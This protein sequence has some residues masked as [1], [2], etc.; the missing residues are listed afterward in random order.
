M[1]QP[2]HFAGGFPVLSGVPTNHGK[3]TG[4]GVASRAIPPTNKDRGTGTFLL[5]MEANLNNVL[6]CT[7]D[8]QA[9]G[10]PKGIK[11]NPDGGFTV[12]D[13]LSSMFNTKGIDYYWMMI[14]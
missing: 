9:D 7:I 5:L 14:Y 10:I 11:F 1:A 4:N 12:F 3:Y 8:S 6:P 2:S 13:P